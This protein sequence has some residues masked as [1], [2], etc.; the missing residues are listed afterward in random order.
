MTGHNARRSS[1]HDRSQ[2]TTAKNRSRKKDVMAALSSFLLDRLDVERLISRFF[3]QLHGSEGILRILAKE[4]ENLKCFCGVVGLDGRCSVQAEQRERNLWQLAHCPVLTCR[5][6]Q[7]LSRFVA[8]RERSLIPDTHTEL[9]R[10]AHVTLGKNKTSELKDTDVLPFGF[11]SEEAEWQNVSIFKKYL[12]KQ[13]GI[14]REAVKVNTNC[15]V[16]QCLNFI[17][18]KTSHNWLSTWSKARLVAMVIQDAKE[19]DSCHMSERKMRQRLQWRRCDMAHVSDTYSTRTLAEEHNFKG[20]KLTTMHLRERRAV[21]PNIDAALA[22]RSCNHMKIVTNSTL[23]KVTSTPAFYL[24]FFLSLPLILSLS[25]SLSPFSSS[26]Y[27]ALLTHENQLLSKLAYYVVQ[28]CVHTGKYARRWPLEKPTRATC[29]MEEL[30]TKKKHKR[31]TIS[32][33]SIQPW[34]TWT[35]D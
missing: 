2:C 3:S 26:P 16:N 25:L 14:K 35:T 11:F 9:K 15:E 5:Q 7:T 28:V 12:K 18:Q 21:Q 4:T 10:A 1:G 23:D 22:K 13:K 27:G 29:H 6:K 24:Y 34:R 17:R 31:K 30:Q 19:V 33:W 20:K 32:R 8:W